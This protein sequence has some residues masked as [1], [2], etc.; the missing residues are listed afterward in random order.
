MHTCLLKRT[1]RSN[2]CPSIVVPTCVQ[3]L[4][5]TSAAEAYCR[6]Q[7]RECLCRHSFAF[8]VVQWCVI[9]HGLCQNSCDLISDSPIQTQKGVCHFHP[10]GQATASQ[11]FPTGREKSALTLCWWNPWLIPTRFSCWSNSGKADILRTLWNMT[12]N[13]TNCAAQE[14]EAQLKEIPPFPTHKGRTDTLVKKP[15]AVTAALHYK[16]MFIDVNKVSERMPMQ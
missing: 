9:L 14:K 1:A 7:P 15:C 5:H 8:L 11:S 3:L 2:S 4:S 6:S 16:H 10:P 13:S 12:E